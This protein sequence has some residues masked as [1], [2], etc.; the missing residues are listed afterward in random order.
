MAFTFIV[1]NCHSEKEPKIKTNSI[2][3]IILIQFPPNNGVPLSVRKISSHYLYHHSNV[4][5]IKFEHGVM[6]PAEKHLDLPILYIS[7]YLPTRNKGKMDVHGMND[8]NLKLSLLD[9]NKL[10]H[11]SSK[12][13]LRSLNSFI[14]RLKNSGNTLDLKIGDGTH[15]LLPTYMCSSSLHNVVHIDLNNSSPSFAIFCQE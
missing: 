8:R 3:G 1:Q 9:F 4:R 7:K 6:G 10:F 13:L 5:N 12:L 11:D 14:S 15:H 2:I